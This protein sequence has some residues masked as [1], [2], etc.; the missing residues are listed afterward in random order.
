ML[1]ISRPEV[2]LVIAIVVYLAGQTSP[3]NALSFPAL[4]ALTLLMA[5]LAMFYQLARTRDRHRLPGV[6]VLAAVALMV[7]YALPW[8]VWPPPAARVNAYFQFVLL[9]VAF[10]AQHVARGRGSIGILF[11]AASADLALALIMN[12]Q[13]VWFDGRSRLAG[14]SHPILVGIEATLVLLICLYVVLQNTEKLK[15]RL[16]FAMLGAGAFYCLTASYTRQAWAAALIGALLLIWLLPGRLRLARNLV[17]TIG[18]V[19]VALLVDWQQVLSEF[20]GGNVASLATATG[21]TE[22]W[23]RIAETGALTRPIGYGYGAISDGDGADQGVWVASLGTNP[24]NSILQVL[25]NGGIVGLA[26]WLLLAALLCGAAIRAS[27]EV[28]PLTVS[29]MAAVLIIAAVNTSMADGLL[30]WWALAIGQTAAWSA[31]SVRSRVA[32]SGARGTF[33]RRLT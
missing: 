1:R 33:R 13:V 24:E 25:L 27:V 26:A 12:N 21:R 3:L 15:V 8:L 2:L 10:G 18:A 9:G 16:A 11:W 14:T 6:V 29:A 31:S 19:V 17:A 20:A 4:K 5:T 7:M 28:R 30:L 32:D 22:I 23:A